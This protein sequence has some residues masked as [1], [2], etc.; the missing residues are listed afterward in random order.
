VETWLLVLLKGDGA[1]VMIAGP[2]TV[3][4]CP[5]T[6]EP[7]GERDGREA[8]HPAASMATGAAGAPAGATGAAM[9]TVLRAA[10]MLLR[11]VS[12]ER[13]TIAWGEAVLEMI[14]QRA[15]APR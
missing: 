9:A 3:S 1:V 13:D 5:A 4:A 2:M 6:R 14:A 7:Y 11:G 15:G 12:Y 10:A 8:S